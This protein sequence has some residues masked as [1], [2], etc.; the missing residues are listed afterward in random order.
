MSNF[1]MQPLKKRAGVS[2]SLAEPTEIH[3]QRNFKDLKQTSCMKLAR[4][5]KGRRVKRNVFLVFWWTQGVQTWLFVPYPTISFAGRFPLFCL[6]IS[7]CL[8]SFCS[9]AKDPTQPVTSPLHLNE[10]CSKASGQPWSF[11]RSG[12]SGGWSDVFWYLRRPFFL[13]LGRDWKK[14][15]LSELR[16]CVISDWWTFCF[17]G[18]IILFCNFRKIWRNYCITSRL[19]SYTITYNCRSINYISYYTDYIYIQSH[20]D[21]TWNMNIRVYIYYNY[22][23]YI[24]IYIYIY[25][26]IHLIVQ[27]PVLS[28]EGNDKQNCYYYNSNNLVQPLNSSTYIVLVFVIYS[29]PAPPKAMIPSSISWA[30]MQ[31]SIYLWIFNCRDFMRSMR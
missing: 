29:G 5:N 14:R 27:V 7:F 20:W 3:I 31:S 10:A 4:V 6:Y 12:E 19:K 1:R 26:C 22:A 24:R 11:A 17:W 23:V 16:S 25:T 30:W 21:M 28:T 13:L 2:P 8:F 9:W 18:Y 15:E